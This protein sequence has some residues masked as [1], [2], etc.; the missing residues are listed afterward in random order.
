MCVCIFNVHLTPCTNEIAV[1]ILFRAILIPIFPHLSVL[2]Q[3]TF[4]NKT[5]VSFSF[6][7]WK[8]YF[9]KNTRP[10]H[11][12][13]YSILPS[14]STKQLG[15]F[16]C[17]C[18][19]DEQAR[20]QRGEVKS[21]QAYKPNE[22]RGSD[23]NLALSHSLWVCS[24]LHF[25]SPILSTCFFTGSPG[26]LAQWW[27]GR[28]L[29]SFICPLAQEQTT[30]GFEDKAPFGTPWPELGPYISPGTSV[31]PDVL[32]RLTNAQIYH[33]VVSLFPPTLGCE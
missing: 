17:S 8:Q 13:I 4:T 33:S 27:P 32:Q 2:W 11:C 30:L 10:S 26:Q 25:L 16:S 18:S 29:S 24:L 19:A 22:W 9:W 14:P 5:A 6:W 12:F 31:A 1:C 20:F 21:T 3:T 7:Y 23:S 28:K 15:G